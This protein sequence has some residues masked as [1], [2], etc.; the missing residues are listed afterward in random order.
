MKAIEFIKKHQMDEEDV[1]ECIIL[2][3]GDVEEP[4]PSH[5][6]RLVEL[7]GKEAAWLHGQMEKSMEPLFWVV[8][9]TGCMSVWQTRVVSPSQ[10]TEAQ[11]D[12]L[13]EL[14]DAAMLAPKYLMQ[15]ADD[16]YVKSVQQAKAG[17]ADNK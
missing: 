14:R 9:Y 3:D 15:K 17:A 2:P 4:V 1:C 13:E 11:M 5:I 8:E 12:A 16:T 7:T 10:P 6:N